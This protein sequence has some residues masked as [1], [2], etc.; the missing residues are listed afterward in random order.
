MSSRL[1]RQTNQ[2]WAALRQEFLGGART[3]ELIILREATARKRGRPT[4]PYRIRRRPST[5]DEDV[6]DDLTLPVVTPSTPP[7][8]V[9]HPDG[10][11]K[12]VVP[13]AEW[14]KR[15]LTATTARRTTHDP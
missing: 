3:R 10:T 9:Y 13:A 5:I 1:H 4:L 7:V 11:V 12:E 2:E 15:T 6:L 8:T 14:R